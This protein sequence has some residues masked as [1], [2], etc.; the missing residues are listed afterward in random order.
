MLNR[1]LA[2]IRKRHQRDDRLKAKAAAA[3]EIMRHGSA[4]HCQ[5]DCYGA[6][7]WL[8]EGGQRIS[9][10]IAQLVITN[11]A[12]AGVGDALPLNID[13]PSQT[14]RYVEEENTNERPS[15][16]GNR[17]TDHT[18]GRRSNQMGS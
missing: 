7:W 8:S 9:D 1:T 2:P 3:I 6:V 4:L 14:W 13:I 18:D 11:P 15:N 12:I 16:K 17:S 10:E 5:H